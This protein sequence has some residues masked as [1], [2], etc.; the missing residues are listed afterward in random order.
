MSEVAASLTGVLFAGSISLAEKSAKAQREAGRVQAASQKLADRAAL[1]QRMRET[2]M[3]QAQIEQAANNVGSGTSSGAMGAFGA[4]STMYAA[5]VAQQK[6]QA[7]AADAMT[8]LGNKAAMYDR[9]SGYLT[10]GVNL[11]FQFV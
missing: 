8:A 4:L 9:Y 5:N 10:Q 6:S 2:R 11:A 7:V 3:R 1:R